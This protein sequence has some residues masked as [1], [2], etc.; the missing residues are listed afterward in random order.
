MALSEAVLEVE[1]RQRSSRNS[2]H[3]LIK[4]RLEWKTYPM[5]SKLAATYSLVCDVLG[6]T[7]KTSGFW[8]LRADK[9]D[10]HARSFIFIFKGQRSHH[11]RWGHVYRY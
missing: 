2:Y 11:R 5:K 9:I 10:P 1:E 6:H 7:K 3:H 8:F 4:E